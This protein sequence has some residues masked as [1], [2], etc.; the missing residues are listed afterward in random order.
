MGTP[1]PPHQDGFYFCLENNLAAT[2]WL[3]LD[4]MDDENG[5]LHYVAGSHKFGILDHQRS[6][7]LGFSQGLTEANIGAYGKDVGCR[8]RRGDLLV[9]HCL[10]IHRAEA[11]VSE[12]LRRAFGAVYYG[13]SDRFD[14]EKHRHYR[15]SVD[16]QRKE[17]GVI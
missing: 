14:A 3:T 10:T 5:T 1:T 11:N 4:D 8:L 12:R 17:M 13:A 9:H 16:S 15:A 2:A 6:D 7:V